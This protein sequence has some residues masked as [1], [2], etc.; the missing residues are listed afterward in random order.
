VNELHKGF[1][2]GWNH[3]RIPLAGRRAALAGLSLYPACRP[4]AVWGQRIAW[5]GVALFGPRCLPGSALH[6]TPVGGGVWEELTD[7][8]RTEIGAF[9][10]VAGYER[11]LSSRP[12]FAVLLLRRGAPLAFA[13]LRPQGDVERSLDMEERALQLVSRARPTAFIAPRV[14][15][16]GVASGWRYFLA[17]A[18]PSR[19][20][21]VP[22]SPP[23]T[24]I[25]AEIRTTLEGLPR[26]PE[27]PS[28][29]QP[30]HGDFT[31]WNLRESRRQL[32][33]VDWEHAQWGPPHADEIGYRIS[34]S[35]LGLAGGAEAW[36]PPPD[37]LEAIQY[38]AGQASQWGGS[39]RDDQH[40]AFALR[41]LRRME[42]QLSPAH[43]RDGS[44]PQLDVSRLEGDSGLLGGPAGSSVPSPPT[45]GGGAKG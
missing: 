39:Q 30:M 28:H 2:P 16:S 17:S 26:R 40:T 36:S 25:A 41:A 42:R 15:S 24:E 14:L 33:L 38:W 18:L 22:Q 11:A 20:H 4:R 7:R 1:P 12:G 27:T 21:R 3:L 23:L 34:A 13:K 43:Q 45:A 44:P 8:W 29:W 37:C 10:A 6:W 9:D 5:L 32:F 19:L 31:P 35:G